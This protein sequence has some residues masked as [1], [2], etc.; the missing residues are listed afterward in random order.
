MGGGAVSAVD[1]YGSLPC[2]RVTVGV[3]Q[4]LIVATDHGCC[5]FP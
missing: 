4:S 1:V 2:Y 3:L 5:D